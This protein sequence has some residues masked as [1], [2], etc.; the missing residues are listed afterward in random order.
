MRINKNTPPGTWW[1]S[2]LMSDIRRLVTATNQL[3]Q[4]LQD[5]VRCLETKGGKFILFV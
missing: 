3:Q 5:A 1:R 4:Q 2:V